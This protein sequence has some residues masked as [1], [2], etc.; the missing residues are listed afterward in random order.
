MTQSAPKKFQTLH[1][2][3]PVAVKRVLCAA[4]ALGLAGQ[5]VAVYAQVIASET[6]AAPATIQAPV[7]LPAQLDAAVTPPHAA[8][9]GSTVQAATASNNPVI[10]ASAPPTA[11]ERPLTIFYSHTGARGNVMKD[12]MD[13][14]RVVHASTTQK[15]VAGQVAL[16]VALLLFGGGGM[17]FRTFEKEDL[18]GESPEDLKDR[19]RLT[20]PAQSLLLEE[21]QRQTLDWLAANPRTSELKFSKPLII[22]SAAWRLVYNSLTSDDKTYQLKLDVEIYKRRDQAS[23]FSDPVQVGKGCHFASKALP[24]HAW[25]AD[26][27]QAV[28]D[29]MPVAVAQCAKE[30]T[31]QLPDLLELK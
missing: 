15:N 4:M 29:L 2:L 10:G 22:S 26:D 25:K 24:L 30:F 6:A 13:D 1:A 8:A 28:A 18:T 27:Y 17:S 7:Q 5:T 12:V 16:N 9:S 21:V 20:N 14:L 3:F 23:F 19:N 11:A 31:A